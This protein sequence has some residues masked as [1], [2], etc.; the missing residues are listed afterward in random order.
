LWLRFLTEIDEN[1]ENVPVELLN[2]E[3]ISDALD[4]L[5]ISAFTK[6]E[7]DYYDNYWDRVRIERTAIEDALERMRK[8]QE[9]Q[10]LAQQRE[11]EAEKQRERALELQQEAQQK[12]E[13]AL[14]QSKIAQQK[15]EEALK[16][17]K[18]AQQKEEE[19]LKQSK[20]AQQKEEEALKQ[21]KIA[22]QKEEEALK[23]SKIA[24]QKEE[25]A[26]NQ[27]AI[28]IQEAKNKAQNFA[29][30]MIKYGET[31]E[32]IMKET[33]LSKDEIEGLM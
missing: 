6:D 31:I 11:A 27:N 17:S 13:E 21:S 10:L 24:Q 30:K 1:T 15:E 14:K 32:D 18:I 8:A 19:A 12:E 3:D 9:L 23:Q 5:Q 25:E 7:L 4:Q 26:L 29:K 33:G 20:I 2:E 16:Q 22:Q 28:L